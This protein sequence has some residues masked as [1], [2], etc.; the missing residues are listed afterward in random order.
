MAVGFSNTNK[1]INPRGNDASPKGYNRASLYSG[2]ALDF[3]GVND[4]VS[5]ADNNNLDFATNFSIV[6]YV[7]IDS[8]QSSRIFYSNFYSSGKGA[9][10]GI[11]DT[12]NNIVKFYTKGAGADNTLYSSFALNTNEWYQVI[13]TYDGATK[14]IYINGQLD[15]SVSYTDSITYTNDNAFALGL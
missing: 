11:S 10:T 1:P 14:K 2:K 3:D 9:A 6:Q 7:L 5:V 15:T 8:L 4:S 13:A 12:T